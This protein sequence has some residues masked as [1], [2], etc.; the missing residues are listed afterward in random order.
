M[1]IRPPRWELDIRQYFIKREP[2]TEDEATSMRITVRK[3]FIYG[4][5]ITTHALCVTVVKRTH[6]VIDENGNVVKDENGNDLKEQTITFTIKERIEPK[7]KWQDL[8]LAPKNIKWRRVET[9]T[10]EQLLTWLRK[11]NVPTKV[12]E[13]LLTAKA[14]RKKA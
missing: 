4:E 5:F 14:T 10:E 13:E 9:L 11:R 1:W 3:L 6:K 2:T 8:N 12:V 7:D